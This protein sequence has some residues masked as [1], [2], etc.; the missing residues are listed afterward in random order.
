GSDPVLPLSASTFRGSGPGP[1]EDTCALY[2]AK[3]Q[4]QR[5]EFKDLLA[6]LEV[7]NGSVLNGRVE[8]NS[9]M[10]E[11][12]KLRVAL[13]AAIA[14]GRAAVVVDEPTAPLDSTTSEKVIEILKEFR[15]LGRTFIISSHDAAVL[16]SADRV[17]D[18]EDLGQRGA[19]G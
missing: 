5:S 2:G 3:T 14:G 8:S 12:E 9:E 11:G 4:D 17:I 19:T 16:A 15:S 1:I 18:I 10:S 13:A 6:R 7:K